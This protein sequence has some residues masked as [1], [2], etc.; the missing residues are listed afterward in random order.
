MKELDLE[1]ISKKKELEL[2]EELLN[3]KRENF[4]KDIEEKRNMLDD[5]T[6]SLSEKEEVLK[7][8]RKEMLDSQR[9]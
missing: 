5:K 8:E 6:T 2:E 9:K 1:E 3:K 7:W 4:D